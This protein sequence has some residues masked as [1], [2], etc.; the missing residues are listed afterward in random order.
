[1]D[2][3]AIERSAIRRRHGELFTT[4][5]RWFL[6]R[7]T[8]GYKG[9][10]ML[11]DMT[12]S[13]VIQVWFAAVALIVVAAVA[14]GAGVTVSTGVMLV[15][16]CLVPPAIVLMVWPGVQ[17]RTASEVLHDADRLG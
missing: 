6:Q 1:M 17:P 5:A 11:R 13:N 3:S 9:D 2:S 15:A 12:R 4:F 8:L 7:R 10:H 16:L 14:F